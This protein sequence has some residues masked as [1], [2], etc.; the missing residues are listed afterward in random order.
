[1]KPNLFIVGMPKAGTS[2]LYF[3][4][5]QHPEIFMSEDKEPNYFCADLI[6]ESDNFHKRKFEDFRYRNEK[7]YLKLFENK[8]KFKIAGEASTQYLF[9]K[10]AAENIYN[11][12]TKAKIII[13]IREPVSFLYSYHSQLLRNVREN[14]LD[15]KKAL[16]FEPERKKLNKYPSNVRFPSQLHYTDWIDYKS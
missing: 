13:I 9:S 4:L 16:E 5:K 7:S 15:F 10:K 2:A 1:M 3:F 6:E 8:D 14:I 11:F 12:N